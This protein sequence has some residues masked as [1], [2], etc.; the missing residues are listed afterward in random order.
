M[1]P[2][3]YFTFTAHALVI[4]FCFFSVPDQTSGEANK[5]IWRATIF[6]CMLQ[7]TSWFLQLNISGRA[8]W[9][10]QKPLWNL[11][12]LNSLSVNWKAFLPPSVYDFY[13]MLSIR[14]LLQKFYLHFVFVPIFSFVHLNGLWP[15]VFKAGYWPQV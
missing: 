10:F 6:S 9:I 12:Q 15:A 5:V 14:P 13:F 2:C 1:E 3:L 4:G 11:C 7:H 8:A